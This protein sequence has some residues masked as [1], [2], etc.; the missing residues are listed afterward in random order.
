MTLALTDR[1]LA[2]A[3]YVTSQEV[4]GSRSH[5]KSLLALDE[6]EGNLTPDLARAENTRVLK[7]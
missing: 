6:L 4:L 1:V 3:G 2:L 7:P 5:L